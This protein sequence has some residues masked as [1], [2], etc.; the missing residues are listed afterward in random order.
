LLALTTMSASHVMLLSFGFPLP[1][2]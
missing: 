2:F 1:G